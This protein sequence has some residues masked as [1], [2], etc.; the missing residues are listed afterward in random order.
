[1]ARSQPTRGVI[2]AKAGN[3]YAQA[4]GLVC[5]RAKQHLTAYWVPAFAG[6][7]AVGVMVS[8]QTTK[9]Y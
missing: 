9:D 5:D 1:M 2:P 8:S 6:M 4:A 7:T 3:Q